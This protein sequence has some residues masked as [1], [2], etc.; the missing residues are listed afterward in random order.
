MKCLRFWI[1]VLAVLLL[2][3]S[4]A[5]TSSSDSTR[6]SLSRSGGT[7]SEIG[8]LVGN[9]SYGVGFYFPSTSDILDISLLKTDSV[10]GLISEISHQRIRN[11]LNFPIQFTVRYDK[12]DIL[13][14]DTCTLIVTLLVDDSVK[15][16]GITLLQRTESGFAE[17]SLSIISV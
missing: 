3:C 1:P 5:S 17:A 8:M 10:T 7:E 15:A 14:T 2:L 16:Q 12:A 9:V 13:D 6:F 11:L 4:C